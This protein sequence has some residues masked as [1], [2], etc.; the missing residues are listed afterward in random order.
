ML[1]E[2]NKLYEELLKKAQD[3]EPTQFQN[4][5]PMNIA[6]VPLIKSL[7]NIGFIFYVGDGLRNRVRLRRSQ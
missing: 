5:N 3:I 7:A 1:E 4:L 6:F 2:A